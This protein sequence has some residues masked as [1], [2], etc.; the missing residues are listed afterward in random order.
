MQCA[1]TKRVWVAITRQNPWLL[2]NC[3]TRRS[4]KLT[5][6]KVR[7][8]LR[9]RDRNN[10]QDIAGIDADKLNDHYATIFTDQS[11]TETRAKLTVMIS[12]MISEMEMFNILDRLRPPAM[13]RDAIPAWFL[14]L[15]LLRPLQRFLINHYL[16]VLYH[17]TA[18]LVV[19]KHWKVAA[20]T[21]VPKIGKPIQ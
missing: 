15:F 2:R 1:L 10:D 3:D 4:I 5:W 20:I 13:S 17:L 21:P 16:P 19:A 9:G 7:Q 18:S 12:E 6:P 14:G 8:I 11:F